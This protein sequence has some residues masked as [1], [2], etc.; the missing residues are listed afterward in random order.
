MRVFQEMI[1][2]SCRWRFKVAAFG[3]LAVTAGL[4]SCQLERH[5]PERRNAEARPAATG[6]WLDQTGDPHDEVIARQFGGMS[7]AMLEIDHRYAELYFAGQDGNWEYAEHQV[8]H[9]QEAMDLALERRPA[10]AASAR[11]YFYPPLD[12]LEEAISRADA[13]AFHAAF[14]ELRTAC[15]SCHEAEGEGF[16]RV[17][18]PTQRRTTIGVEG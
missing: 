9:L 10:R 6:T 7:A 3:T 8:E 18:V 13:E 5:E 17:G 1:R 16:M 11:A 14:S 15:N 4:A 12:R 2:P